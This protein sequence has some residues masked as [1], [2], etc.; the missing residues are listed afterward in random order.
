MVSLMWFVYSCPVVYRLGWQTVLKHQT[1]DFWST[2]PA[3]I[4]LAPSLPEPNSNLACVVMKWVDD[5]KS[6]VRWET[7][8]G[9]YE[10]VQQQVFPQYETK[11][12]EPVG[13][14]I[15]QKVVGE[16]V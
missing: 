1:F 2:E 10:A 14:T 11:V 7:P 4:M 15:L 12:I 9:R 5:V 8:R 3:C 6:H 13:V 16:G